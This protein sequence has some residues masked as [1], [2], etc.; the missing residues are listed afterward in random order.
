MWLAEDATALVPRVN[1]DAATDQIIGLILPVDDK[2]GCP[3]TLSYKATSVDEII[4]HTKKEKSK[5]VYLVMA[6]PLDE[7]LPP[8]ILQLYGLNM[9]FTAKTV[10]NRWKHTISELEKYG[11]RVEGF[12]S[13]GD[14]RLLSAMCK[15][16][17]NPS[18]KPCLIQDTIHIAS[19]L[20]NRLLKVEFEMM[21]GTSKVCLEHLKKL[22]RN[23]PKEIHG[24]TMSDVCPDDRQNFSS[25]E[26]IVSSRVLYALEVYVPESSATVKYL[27]LS[28]DVTTS[29]METDL[30][31]A[32]RLHRIW[33][34]VFFIRIWR[35]NIKTSSHHTL[36]KR[37][38]T[39]NAFKCI[40]I[41]ARNLL[42]LNYPNFSQ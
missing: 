24:L 28:R 11:I 23:S 16:Y 35:E 14:P 18:F 34:A 29:F 36:E 30:K 2:S 10:I 40:E 31:P 42:D 41:N 4:N 38:I 25:F 27:K 26:K 17:F 37:F 19:K 5:M 12:S 22:I 8:F 39:S 1:Y 21:F 7:K 20:R 33:R 3:I 15:V 6:Q 13:D 32:D 9:K